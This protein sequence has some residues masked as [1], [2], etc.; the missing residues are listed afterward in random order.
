MV[1]HKVLASP[2]NN[3]RLI[4]LEWDLRMASIDLS[5]ND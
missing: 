2:L 4:I 5:S 1:F 3:K